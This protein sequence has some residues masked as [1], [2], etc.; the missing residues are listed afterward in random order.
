MNHIIRLGTHAEKVYLQ[1]A[2]AWYNEVLI[3][4]NL[5]DFT[6][7]STSYLVFELGQRHKGFFIDPVT[8]AFALAPSHL[9]SKDSKGQERP[10][11]TFLSL[12]KEYG[13]VDQSSTQIPHVDSST[14]QDANLQQ[15][16][17]FQVLAYQQR[18]VHDTLQANS[19]FISHAIGDVRPT[20]LVAPY[21]YLPQKDAGWS[22]I[23]ASLI[24]LSAE[25][26]QKEFGRGVWGV[27]CFDGLILDQNDLID[28]ICEQYGE[29]PC[30]GYALWA[31]DFDETRATLSQIRGLTRLVETLKEKRPDA[32]ILSMYAGYFTALLKWRGVSGISHGV[33]YGERRG[34]VPVVGGGIPP[35]R[36]Y[37]P[38]IHEEISIPELGSVAR[39]YTTQQFE[40][41]IC[42]CVICRELLRKGVQEL[43]D[44]YMDTDTR[45]SST[46]SRGFP[47]PTVYRMT[48]FH[49]LHNR[50]LE[51][52]RLEAAAD[53][54]PL[55]SPLLEA[56]GKFGPILG[57]SRV[58]FLEAWNK[59]LQ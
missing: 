46:G 38:P 53:L 45:K 56:Y 16:F 32:D 43:I 54:A 2:T 3:N 9:M 35:A 1:R 6:A 15:R 36:Y 7:S 40:E 20:R 55:T 13:L 59:A 21:F 27:I 49:F 24:R 52:L 39:N 33:G 23:N 30:E 25:I 31:A 47:T 5:L 8:Y 29:L 34:I 14:L 26:A 37:L 51:L 10:K 58:T 50:H 28:E 42:E 48:K 4:A 11:Q 18:K 22:S 44:Q 41:E 57:Y 17:C 19:D 12:A